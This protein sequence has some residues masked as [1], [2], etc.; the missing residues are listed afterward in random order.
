MKYS[1][2][3]GQ[4]N[5]ST[6]LSKILSLSKPELA[7]KL[8]SQIGAFDDIEY[9]AEKYTGIYLVKIVK[10]SKHPDADKLNVCL[11]D[12][13]GVV[14]N[15]DRDK[16]GLVQVVCGAPNAKE[17]MFV[18]WASPGSIVPSTFNDKEPFLL[19]KIK[20]RGVESNGMLASEKEL[21]LS[22]EHD[23]ILELTDK[24][25]DK[26]LLKP[27]TPFSKLFDLDDV[28]VDFENKMFTHRPD[29]F[30]HLG[31]SRE[32]AGIQAINFKSPDW[33]KESKLKPHTSESKLK[34]SVKN[35]AKEVVPRYTAVCVEGIDIQPSPLWLKAYL[36][37]L[38]IRPINNVVD[39]TNYIMVLTGQPLHAFDYDKV[40]SNN[41]ATITVRMAK[42]D[43]KLKILG[44]KDI[45]LDK[46]DI[47][48]TDGKEPIA[49]GGVMGGANSE[50]DQNTTR[51]ILESANFNMYS[52]RRTSMRHGLFTDA[53][54]RF[55]KGQPEVQTELVL[56]KA[57][58]MFKELIPSTKSAEIID[59]NT[60]SF[61]YEHLSIPVSKVNSVLGLSLSRE[62]ISDILNYVEIYSHEML[63]EVCV[64]PPFWR[65]DLEIDEDVIEE[66][67]R[68][69]GFNK[70]DAKLP[71]RTISPARKNSMVELK[72]AISSQ[73]S[74]LGANEVLTYN[75][76]NESLLKRA[77]QNPEMAY[78]IRNALSP[79]LQHYRLSLIPNLL[80][81]VHMNIKAGGAEFA[82]FELGK[83]HV[84]DHFE[85]GDKLPSEFKR[86]GFVYANKAKS[87]GS[88]YF[89]AKAY[90]EKLL[91]S[92][93]IE[94]RFIELGKEMFGSKIPISSP[95]QP[96]LSAGVEIKSG[97][98]YELR[99]IVGQFTNQVS[100]NFKL[101]ESCAGFELDLDLISEEFNLDPNYKPL[102][103]FPSIEQDVT[104][105]VSSEQNYQSALDELEKKLHAKIAKEVNYKITPKYIYQEKPGQNKHVT[106]ALEFWHPER[107][108]QTKEVTIS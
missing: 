98:H 103:K 106:F 2:K 69:Y 5:S 95:F 17:G 62:Q 41:S 108:L 18:A 100:K 97:S 22:S 89:I 33:Y 23:G 26:K 57:L 34:L 56:H 58:D 99:C 78:K 28:I 67:G 76:V 35:E 102:N 73:L 45:T 49:L 47:V 61:E 51:I 52:I 20:L 15:I 63:D 14:K 107:T 8:N 1:F 75:F 43:E 64:T 53:V 32:V 11:I 85:K 87:K 30:G 37:R 39:I 6:D 104:I 88:P 46:A 93:N 36:T 42:K 86:L 21:N 40:K 70:I 101:P 10:V 60:S 80:D 74:K 9:L 83:S 24:D 19:S 16:D 105:S 65:K 84:K 55:T 90:L 27:G 71:V 91:K 92:L 38:G 48:I 94:Y 29:C 50:V 79:D 72:T 4:V 66:I 31:I 44:G 81:K 82:L 96:G 7:E 77:G 68:L 59:L 25:L 12:D 54:T 3:L 13:G